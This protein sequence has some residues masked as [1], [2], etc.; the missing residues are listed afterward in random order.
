MRICCAIQTSVIEANTAEL[1]VTVRLTNVDL[2]ADKNTAGAGHMCILLIADDD[3]NIVYKAKVRS[4]HRSV[5]CVNCALEAFLLT[6]LLTY[7]ALPLSVRGRLVK[8]NACVIFSFSVSR[9]VSK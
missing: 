6:Y 5:T 4:A 7:L 1:M 2:L 3:N 8:F 9:H